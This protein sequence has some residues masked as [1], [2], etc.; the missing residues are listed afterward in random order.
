M[1]VTPSAAVGAVTTCLLMALVATPASAQVSSAT[2]SGPVSAPVGQTRLFLGPTARPLPQGDGYF[3][4]HGIVPA[5]QVGITDRVSIGAGSFFGVGG[6]FWVTPKVQLVR[7]DAIS[8]SATLVHFVAPGEGNLGFAFAS[9]THGGAA[10]G[11]TFGVGA[12]YAGGWDEDD[13]WAAGGP[14]FMVGAD[15]QLSPRVVFLSENYIVAG[16]GAM[17]ING[18]R[19]SWTRFMLDAGAMILV[20]DGVAG[21]PIVNFAWRF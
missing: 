14:F 17:L 19:A 12:A 11:I 20:G 7:R 8:V 2:P 1:S 3:V 10:G 5:F 6:N 18:I 9:A 4:L 21:G 16:S 13:D 15:R